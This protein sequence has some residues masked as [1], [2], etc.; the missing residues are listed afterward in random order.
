MSN[1]SLAIQVIKTIFPGTF[2]YD[3]NDK[4]KQKKKSWTYW[5]VST[6]YLF[7]LKFKKEYNALTDKNLFD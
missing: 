1:T 2:F 4:Q 7:Y 6:K 3:Q 5:K